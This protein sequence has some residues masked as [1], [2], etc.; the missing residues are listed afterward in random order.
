MTEF[1][2][3]I[4]FTA[5]VAQDMIKSPLKEG[6]EPSVWIASLLTCATGLDG[7]NEMSKFRKRIIGHSKDEFMMPNGIVIH[8]RW[9][10][11]SRT[12][13]PATNVSDIPLFLAIVVVPK[14]AAKAA[15]ERVGLGQRQLGSEWF[16]AAACEV[17]GRCHH[18]R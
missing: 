6:E 12:K 4:D 17:R 5:L 2:P 8:D 9:M 11:G 10:I 1:A 18:G 15:L 16:L 3:R 7:G 14:T 13:M